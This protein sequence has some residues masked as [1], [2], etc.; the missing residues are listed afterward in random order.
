MVVCD[1]K[2]NR[3]NGA[4]V[5]KEDGSSVNGD[6]VGHLNP[7]N[8]KRPLNLIGISIKTVRRYS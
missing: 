5:Y 3:S 2:T 8:R 1:S 4:A 7:L 6:S